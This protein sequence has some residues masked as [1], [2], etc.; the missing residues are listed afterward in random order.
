MRIEIC[1]HQTC[2]KC[3][4]RWETPKLGVNPKYCPVCL[5][6]RWNVDGVKPKQTRGGNR[7]K[8][9]VNFAPCSSPSL[10]PI[11]PMTRGRLA[12]VVA[13][14]KSLIR[15]NP[16]VYVRLR[17]FRHTLHFS[18]GVLRRD[19]LMIGIDMRKRRRVKASWL[20]ERIEDEIHCVVCPDCMGYGFIEGE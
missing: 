4:S 5:T 3:G 15:Q 14:I 1:S 17:D 16:N 11:P 18:L 20:V 12:M 6:K 7:A 9:R 19:L 8:E 2:K 13:Y 10:P